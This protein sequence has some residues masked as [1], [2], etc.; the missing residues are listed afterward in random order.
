M[1]DGTYPANPGLTIEGLAVL[2]S[3]AK[4]KATDLYDHLL[5]VVNK[6][7]SN[8]G[9]HNEEGIVAADNKNQPSAEHVGQYIVRGLSAIYQRN[10]THSSLRD[11]IRQYL[12]VQYNAVLSNA[13]SMGSNRNIYSASWTGPPSVSNFD[14]NSQT[15]AMSILVAAIPVRDSDSDT[16]GVTS[17]G[18]PTPTGSNNPVPGPRPLNIGAIAG[19][20]IGGL[21]LVSL[22]LVAALYLI[23]RHLRSV[24]S[25]K[26]IEV[27]PESG[28]LQPF[29]LISEKNPPRPKF[30]LSLPATTASGF[31]GSSLLTSSSSTE[32]FRLGSMVPTE[33]LFRMLNER[34]QSGR[35]WRGEEAPPEY[36]SH[37][38]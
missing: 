37:R 34:L 27:E 32:P 6:T 16:P 23:R 20:V 21:A 10:E 29:T 26:G 13:R 4:A 14:F 18:P 7:V 8:T 11:Y 35:E 19:G 5:E 22:I 1:R 25:R 24:S 12:G 3:V 9:W 17:A 33:E 38:T 2:A 15:N 28:Q 31:S 36:A 30:H